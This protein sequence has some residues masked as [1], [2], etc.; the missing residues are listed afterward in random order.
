MRKKH[1]WI[2]VLIFAA[3]GG[4]I[5]IRSFASP[6]NPYN[7]PTE[8]GIATYYNNAVVG[9][10]G[11]CAA[12]HYARGKTIKVTNKK[13]GNPLY[14]TSLICE[15]SDAG[16]FG[17]GRVV[18][19]NT[20]DFRKLAGSTSLG[21]LQVQ[22][23]LV[24]PEPAPAPPPTP[25]EPPTLPESPA[26]PVRLVPRPASPPRTTFEL[27]IQLLNSVFNILP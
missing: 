27:L 22:L 11:H 5:I 21:V 14:D 12:I 24:E 10:P 25:P 18:D 6:Y 17:D 20:D 8:T 19:L 16:P 15:V 23:D 9:G 3:I 2:V 4:Y 1:L 26:P 13:V 7:P